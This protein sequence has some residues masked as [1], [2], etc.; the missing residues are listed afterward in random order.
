MMAPCL[1]NIPRSVTLHFKAG[2]RKPYKRRYKV[3]KI[4][5]I[6]L[7][8]MLAIPLSACASSPHH[9]HHHH[10]HHHSGSS[11]SGSV[12]IHERRNRSSISFGYSWSN[13]YHHHYRHSRPTY[14]TYYYDRSPRDSSRVQSCNIRPHKWYSSRRKPPE[15]RIFPSSNGL[16]CISREHIPVP[17]GRTLVVTRE[18]PRTSY[19]CR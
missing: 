6:V 17:D 7:F 1:T 3:K 18:W 13:H 16:C 19:I 14:R 10:P 2:L 11:T 5:T 15:I 12:V 4:I 9:H 8:F